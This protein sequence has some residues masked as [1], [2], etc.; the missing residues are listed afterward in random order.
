LG[1]ENFGNGDK[2]LDTFIQTN[3]GKKPHWAPVLKE[4]NG[5]IGPYFGLNKYVI[6]VI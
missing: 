3:V 6:S 1:I 5:S 2:W 4:T